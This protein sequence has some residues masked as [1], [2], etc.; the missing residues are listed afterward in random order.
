MSAS[1]GSIAATIGL[2]TGNPT[3]PIPQLGLGTYLSPPE[4]TLASCLSALET[5]Y[6]HIDTAQYYANEEEVGQAIVKSGI[7]RSEIFV[8]TKILKVAGSVDENYAHLLES[9]EKIDGRKDGYVDLFLIHSPRGGT[10]KRRDMWLALER[11]YEEGKARAIGVSNFGVGHIEEL[12][13]VG[14][15]WPPHVNQFEVSRTTCFSPLCVT[16]LIHL[17]IFSRWQSR[18]LTSSVITR[19]KLHPW[20]Q[21]KDIVKYCQDHNIV[22]QAYCPI[23][24]N[25]KADDP[26]LGQTAQKHNVT[27]NQVLIKWSLQKG[28]VSLPKSDNP[29]RIRQNA[30]VYNFDLDDQDVAALDALDQG[31]DGAIV[32]VVDNTAAD[33]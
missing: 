14:K 21:Q 1:K 5:G 13:G 3:V 8:T 31:A 12:K 17:Y 22:V 15:V 4:R 18:S 9:L 2:A 7:P 32:F 28:F 10:K 27:P 33:K 6:R 23:V 19:P 29:D 26:T 24:R 16:G 30:D 11:L 25:Q 20:C